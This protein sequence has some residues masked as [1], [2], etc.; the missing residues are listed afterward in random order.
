MTRCP[1]G[2]LCEPES[3]MG[4][5]TQVD[6]EKHGRFSPEV[7]RNSQ[8]FGELY[9]QRSGIERINGS[10]KKALGER[11]FSSQGR[12]EVVV[13]LSAMT[14]AEAVA[15]RAARGTMCVLLRRD[16]QGR[17]LFRDPAEPPV[18]WRATAGV[19]ALEGIGRG[20]RRRAL[21]GRLRR[22]RALP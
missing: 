3:K 16:A 8:Q 17:A 4:P 20:Q 12:L 1:L 14:E 15:L 2:S 9:K 18:A 6:V 19:V 5:L 22:L 11:P 21:A 7:P 10:L 13:D